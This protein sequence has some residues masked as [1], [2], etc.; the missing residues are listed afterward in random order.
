MCLIVLTP[1]YFVFAVLF[2]WIRWM[3]LPVAILSAVICTVQVPAMVFAEVYYNLENY[4]EALVMC[5]RRKSFGGYDSSIL[6]I[7]AILCIAALAVY[8][9]TLI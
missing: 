4:G 9:F 7:A 1:A 6:D 3:Q 8:N 5:R 2:G